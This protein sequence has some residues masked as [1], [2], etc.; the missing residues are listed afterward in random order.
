MQLRVR[1]AW[2]IVDIAQTR[3]VSK[4]GLC[5]AQYT[6]FFSRR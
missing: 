5:F 1:N 3:D 2:G 4:A 6:A